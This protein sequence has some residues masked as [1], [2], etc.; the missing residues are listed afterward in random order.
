MTQQACQSTLQPI[1][2]QKRIIIIGATSGIGLALAESYL[3]A[4]HLVG[5][6]GRNESVLHDMQ[7]KYLG[8]AYIETMDVTKPVIAAAQ[9]DNMI[10]AMKGADI[11]IVNAGV[12]FVD[13]SLG[14]E[15]QQQTI[16]TNVLGFSAIC[17]A[18][19]HYF[20]KQKKGHLVGISS[21][22]SLAGSDLTPSYSAS[23][24]YVTN[25]LAGLRKKFIKMKLTIFVTNILP[26]FVDTPMG[27]SQ[28]R[29]WQSSTEKAAKQIINAIHRKK[30]T[31]YIT[32]RWRLI[33]WLM[34]ILPQWIYNRI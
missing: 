8:T 5:L 23:K 6:T 22:A 24:A 7:D 20:I 4:G 18:A 11:I 14:W 32:K 12:G 10:L 3:T 26:G 34:K 2:S 1:A 19:S 31:A 17:T 25:Y 9:L 13:K 16:A 30:K 15:K 27:Q 33:A 28:Q 29:F 21:I